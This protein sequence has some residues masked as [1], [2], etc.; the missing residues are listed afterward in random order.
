MKIQQNDNST[1]WK[2]NKME[3]QQNEKYKM[4]NERNEKYKTDKMKNNF[5]FVD[6]LPF[7]PQN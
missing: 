2:F 7:C 4:K 5:H 1:K 3:I 6:A